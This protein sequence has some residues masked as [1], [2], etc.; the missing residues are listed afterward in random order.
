MRHQLPPLNIAII[1]GTVSQEDMLYHESADPA[2]SSTHAIAKSLEKLGA[3]TTLLNIANPDF[4]NIITQHDLIFP[5]MHGR[6]G[7]DGTLQGY[8]EYLNVPYVNSGVLASAVGMDKRVSK[9]IA[10]SVG[11]PT[12]PTLREFPAQ[13]LTVTDKQSIIKAIDGGSSVGISIL[14]PRQEPTEALKSIL[15]QGFSN[16]IQE[17]FIEGPTATVPVITIENKPTALTPIIVKTENKYYDAD[18]KLHGG[19]KTTIH[20]L[21]VNNPSCASKIQEQAINLYR[22]L[23]CSGAIRLDY[24]INDKHGAL[25]MEFNT[26][27]GLQPE[28]NIIKSA[29]IDGYNYDDIIYLLVQSALQ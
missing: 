21:A 18:T 5:N 23:N 24:I 4:A 12:I 14:P 17:P 29:Q 22:T 27:P 15:E 9:R 26:S 6:F 3:K 20:N 1:H 2:T 19:N 7:E 13:N 16:V 11:I 28:S 8:L 10:E 25:F